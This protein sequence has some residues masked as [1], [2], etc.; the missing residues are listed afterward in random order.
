MVAENPCATV[1][2]CLSGSAGDADPD[3]VEIR[4]PADD[5]SD[6]PAEGRA[7]RSAL[8]DPPDRV[9]GSVIEILGNA[10]AQMEFIEQDV[11]A[12]GSSWLK[13]YRVDG[14]EKSK[15]LRRRSVANLGSIR[16]VFARYG[17]G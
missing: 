10:E 12:H 4:V 6:S 14:D 1:P 17:Q 3:R 8:Q 15:C 9:A 2:G 5:L 16:F 13:P 7:K 11:V